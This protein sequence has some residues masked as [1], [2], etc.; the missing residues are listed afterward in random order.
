M[1]EN[2]RELE[3]QI[4]HTRSEMDETIDALSQRLSIRHMGERAANAVMR[5]APE[6]PEAGRSFYGKHP[7]LVG[8]IALAAG[9]GAGFLL[10][11]PDTEGKTRSSGPGLMERAKS[12]YQ[13]A[14]HKVQDKAHEM[15]ENTKHALQNR[16][17]GGESATKEAR[18]QARE[19]A[20]GMQQVAK[21]T[22]Q[23]GKQEARDVAQEAKEGARHVKET[24]KREAERQDVTAED[25][26][27]R[28]SRIREASRD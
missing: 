22:Y 8:S 9:A 1:T 4:D 23:V 16:R 26:K 17:Q 15:Q 14:R 12:T 11:P 19:H 27:E 21:S 2:P 3:R 10:S 13:E 25:A 20:A 5:R 18:E 7:M 6:P 28:A 24:A